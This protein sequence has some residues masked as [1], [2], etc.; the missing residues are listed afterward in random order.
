M[1]CDFG[2]DWPTDVEECDCDLEEGE[3]VCVEVEEGIVIPFPNAC[4]A[5]CLGFTEEDFVEECDFGTDWPTSDCD[6]DFE[7]EEVCVEIEEGFII[8]FPNACWAECEGFTAEDFVEC[9]FGD[10]PTDECGCEYV[11]DPVCVELEDGTVLTFLNECVAECEG[12]TAEDFVDCGVE[13]P[14]DGTECDCEFEEGEEVCVEVEEGI[15]IPFPNAC[16]A[17]CFGFTSDDFVEDCDF[18][19]D[20]PTSDCDC[21]FEGEEVCVEIEEGF[22]IPFPNACWAECEGYT[23]EDFVECDFGDDWPTDGEE[24]DCD[25]EVVDEVCVEVEEDVI[26]TFINACVAECFG[27]TTEDFVDCED[28]GLLPE[29]LS[30]TLVGKQQ[31]SGVITGNTDATNIQ[32]S[33]YPNPTSAVA[34]VSLQQMEQGAYNWSLLDMNGRVLQ[35]GQGYNDGG[36]QPIDVDLSNYEQGIYFVRILDAS[37][38]QQTLKV[39]KL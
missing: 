16:F 13:W 39:A 5:E 25:F 31:S 12:Y 22:V 28:G 34:R 7:G 29:V 4:V 21:D 35:D 1:E 8:P 24:C 33:V 2:N 19:T 10:W 14:T 36:V 26:F 32:A 27:F 9:D 23:A 18:G 11:C 38:A 3:E 30:H 37:G 6:C 15:V 20:W 17:E